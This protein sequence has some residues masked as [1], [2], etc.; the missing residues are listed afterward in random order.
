VN[1]G[2][3]PEF[4]SDAER[5]EWEVWQRFNNMSKLDRWLAA[6]GVYTIGPPIPP[7]AKVF[8]H[9]EPGEAFNAAGNAGYVACRPAS[10]ELGVSRTTFRRIFDKM[11]GLKIA[12]VV[13]DGKIRG[14]RYHC[15]MLHRRSV[16]R[17]KRNLPRW[18]K[19]ALVGGKKTTE[20][21]IR[22]SG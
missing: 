1:T 20:E 11:P 5:Y 17:V 9:K 21:T 10:E 6:D 14:S 22:R 7:K 18:V 4:E 13:Y 15:R 3:I 12:Y 16:N 8:T 19:G 2:G